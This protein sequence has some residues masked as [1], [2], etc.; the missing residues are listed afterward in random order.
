MVLDACVLYC[1]SSLLY[2]KSTNP[3]P[4]VCEIVG[5]SGMF[6]PRCQ[7]RGKGDEDQGH[8]VWLLCSKV[9]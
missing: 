1:F 9:G 4:V 2:T 6:V 5:G 8:R 7:S 3:P